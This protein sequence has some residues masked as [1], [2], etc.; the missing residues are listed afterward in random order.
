MGLVSESMINFTILFGNGQTRQVAMRHIPKCILDIRP[1]RLF[2]G[3]ILVPA[4]HTQGGYLASRSGYPTRLPNH[5]VKT[6]GDSASQ[7][8]IFRPADAGRFKFVDLNP[9]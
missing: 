4:G 6:K 3:L 2:K 8:S 5:F 1:D 7:V 9:V